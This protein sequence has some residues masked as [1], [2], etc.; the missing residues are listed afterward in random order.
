MAKRVI[1]KDGKVRTFHN[2][3]EKFENNEKILECGKKRKVNRK[4]GEVTGRVATDFEL[5]KAYGYNQRVKEERAIYARA[6]NNQGFGT[7]TR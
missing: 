4:T 2:P 3:Q 1:C 5:G 6:K 7:L